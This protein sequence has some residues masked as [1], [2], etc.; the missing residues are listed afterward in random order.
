MS[1]LLSD[2][3]FMQL[4]IFITVA[5]EKKLFQGRKAASFDPACNY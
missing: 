4:I 1:F 2:I 3:N 5:H